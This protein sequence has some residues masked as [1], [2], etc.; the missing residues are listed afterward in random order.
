ME[1]ISM[2]S[3]SHLKGLLRDKGIIWD[4]ADRSRDSDF[5][6][7]AEVLAEWADKAM[8]PRQFEALQRVRGRGV[9]GMRA[10][11]ALSPSPR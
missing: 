5:R 3:G 6:I 4:A 10:R 9:L 1:L 11:V 2:N 7:M 8:P